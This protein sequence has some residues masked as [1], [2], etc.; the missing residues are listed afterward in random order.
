MQGVSWSDPVKMGEFTLR[1]RVVME[2]MTRNRNDWDTG[3]ANDLVV[4]YYTQRASAGLI[5]SEKAAICQRA[6]SYPGTARLYLQEHAEGWKKV[7]QAVHERG[8]I[9]F[10][11]LSH[12]GRK[13]HSKRTGGL[14][15]WAPSAITFPGKIKVEGEMVDY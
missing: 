8:G 15:P 12:D 5:C 10:V 9:I 13:N 7:T 2:S 6:N 1:N 3:I 4:E 11:Q 14:E